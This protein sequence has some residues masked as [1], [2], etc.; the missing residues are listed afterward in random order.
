MVTRNST[1]PHRQRSPRNNNKSPPSIIFH[2]PSPPT[3]ICR[4]PQ[5]PA[6]L[7]AQIFSHRRSPGPLEMDQTNFV[8]LQESPGRNYPTRDMGRHFLGGNRLFRSHDPLFPN[9]H[10]H[11]RKHRLTNGSSGRTRPSLPNVPLPAANVTPSNPPN[12]SLFPPQT[13]RLRALLHPPLR[14]HYPRPQTY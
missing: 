8:A 14:I 3:G 12:R 1:P 11:H 2:W 7:C 10:S 6:I 4:P 13:P 5:P 9:P